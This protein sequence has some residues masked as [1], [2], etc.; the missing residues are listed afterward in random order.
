[1]VEEDLASGA[2]RTVSL[3]IAGPSGLAGTAGWIGTISPLDVTIALD[4][5]TLATGT[6]YHLGADRGGS[7]LQTQT[8]AGGLAS[9]SVT[10]TSDVTVKVRIIFVATSL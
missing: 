8:T 6:A 5:T 7:Y 1:V 9:M 10:N 2:T 4:R 3:E